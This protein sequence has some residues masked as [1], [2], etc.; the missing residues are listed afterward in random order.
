MKPTLEEER[1]ALLEQFEASRA[2]YRRMLSDSHIQR[3]SSFVHQT[4]NASN[5][6][7]DFPHS[8]TMRWL[9]A[10]RWQLAF[11]LAGFILLRPDRHLVNRHA[12]KNRRLP[13]YRITVKG[14]AAAGAGLLQSRSSWQLAARM[15]GMLLRWM[16]ER[17][18]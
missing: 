17:R 13:A 5:I 9:I 16:Q 2:V 14:L 1:H 4:G 7:P 10:H 18:A 12:I 6:G 8:H 3:A 15:T 11:G